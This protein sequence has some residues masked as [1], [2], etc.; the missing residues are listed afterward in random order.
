[1]KNL[2]FIRRNGDTFEVPSMSVIE[3]NNT[4]CQEL[5]GVSNCP[6]NMSS[7]QAM[8]WADKKYRETARLMENYK[9][10]F[11]HHKQLYAADS[12]VKSLYGEG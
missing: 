6:K 1:M 7:S 2:S 8:A 11:L 4:L 3:Y 9:T 10:V 5:F 12:K